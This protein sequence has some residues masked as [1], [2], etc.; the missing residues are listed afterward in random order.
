VPQT[1][2]ETAQKQPSEFC[3][4]LTSCRSLSVSDK[5]PGWLA[6]TGIMLVVF[7]T[8]AWWA[9]RDTMDMLTFQIRLGATLPK[10]TVSMPP[11]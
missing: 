1:S 3:A 9:W 8:S 5:L 11:A 4:S 6:L 2:D 10:P 7:S